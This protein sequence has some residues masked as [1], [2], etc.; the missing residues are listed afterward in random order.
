[1]VDIP[2]SD[3][4]SKPL[5]PHSSSYCI[6]SKLFT[7]PYA[8]PHKPTFVCV[9]NISLPITSCEGPSSFLIAKGQA[10]CLENL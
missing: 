5:S 3:S 8:A 9:L 1:M 10:P 7:P 6:G 2:P 4:P